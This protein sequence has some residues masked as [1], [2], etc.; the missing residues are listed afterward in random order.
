[1]DLVNMDVFLQQKNIATSFV[2]IYEHK[3][4]NVY[5]YVSKLTCNKWFT[6]KTATNRNG[7]NRIGDIKHGDTKMLTDGKCAGGI[8]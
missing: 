6:V 1:M 5:S 3:T 7:D 2:R 4:F 8:T